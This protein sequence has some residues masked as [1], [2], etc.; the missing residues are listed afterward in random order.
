MLAVHHVGLVKISSAH[1]VFREA[2][3][4]L[5]SDAPWARKRSRAEIVPTEALK[6]FLGKR[7]MYV[8]IPLSVNNFIPIPRWN[9]LIARW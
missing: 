9:V 6:I 7:N 1:L 3:T 5:L 4:D 2:T 8:P